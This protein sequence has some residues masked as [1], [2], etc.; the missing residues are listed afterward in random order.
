MNSIFGQITHFTTDLSL[1]FVSF[2][3]LQITEGINSYYVCSPLNEV[4]I[5]I[6]IVCLFFK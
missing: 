1:E 3:N 5:I 4:L 2:S 6:C